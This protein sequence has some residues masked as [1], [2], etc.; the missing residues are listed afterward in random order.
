MDILVVLYLAIREYE[1]RRMITSQLEIASAVVRLTHK[2]SIRQRR[3]ATHRERRFR[4]TSGIRLWPRHMLIF[5]P[6]HNRCGS[7]V[8]LLR[9]GD[10]SQTVASLKGKLALAGLVIMKNSS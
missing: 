9:Q 2:F 5:K 10:H 8:A 4:L 6:S 3:E 7:A 1:V